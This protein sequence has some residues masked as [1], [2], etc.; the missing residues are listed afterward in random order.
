MASSPPHERPHPMTT[1]SVQLGRTHPATQVRWRILALLVF[2]S[3]V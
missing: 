1:I 3:F 2:L